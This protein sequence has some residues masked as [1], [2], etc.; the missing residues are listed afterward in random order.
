[1]ADQ[2]RIK[3]G[4]ENGAFESPVGEELQIAGTELKSKEK[5]FEITV[6]EAALKGL[7]ELGV[8]RNGDGTMAI[9]AHDTIVKETEKTSK[10]NEEHAGR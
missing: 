5:E 9:T 4:K 1:M 6:G 7:Q 2:E 10:A 3:K 8:N